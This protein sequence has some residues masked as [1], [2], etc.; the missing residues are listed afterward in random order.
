MRESKAEKSLA[1]NKPRQQMIPD[2]GLF[3]SLTEKTN[4]N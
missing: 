2:N 3:Q 4:S 1:N